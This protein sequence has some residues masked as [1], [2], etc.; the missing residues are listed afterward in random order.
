M[1][2]YLMIA[3]ALLV[4]AG[5]FSAL[6]WLGSHFA[7]YALT[8]DR[9]SIDKPAPQLLDLGSSAVLDLHGS[10]F[11]KQTS[12][13][14]FMD[15]NSNEAVIGSFPLKGVFN[16]SLLYGDFL[17]LGS[18]SD[19]LK[20][21]NVKNPQ[22]PQLLKEYLVGISIADIQRSGNRLFLSRGQL[23]I[24]IMQIRKDGF[25]VH[26][27]DILLG[28]AVRAC[29]FVDGFLFVAAGSQGLLVYDVRQLEQIELVRIIKPGTFV[30]KI[31]VSGEFLFYTS[32]KNKIEIY[33][34]TEPKMPVFAGTI[35][36]SAP[37]RDILV[38]Q[39]RLY[40]ATAKGLFLYD[41]ADPGQP[42][43]LNNWFDFGSVMKIFPGLKHIY[44]SDSLSGLRIVD[45][46]AEY[47][48]G[49]INL[50]IDPRIIVE[51]SNC[52]YVAG[53]NKGILI[54]DKN[55][56]LSRQAVKTINIPGYSL[57]IFIKKHW[58]YI[59][60]SE[61]GVLLKDLAV[62]DNTI[63][64]LTSRG[65]ESFIAD[66]NLLF[67]AQA[68][69]GIEIFDI[70]DP[71]N[72]KSIAVWPERKALRLTVADGYLV[73]SKGH[74][75]IELI[76]ISDIKQ[77]I[78]KDVLPYIHV[79]NIVS[80]GHFI[81]VA[82]KN[83]GL[84]IYEI[85]DNSKL[86][87]LSSLSTPFPMNRFD[88]TMAVHVQEGIA[89]VANGRSGLLIIDVKNPEKPKILSSIDL[90]GFC[91]GLRVSDAK[92]FIISHCSGISVVNIEDPEKPVL[93]CSISMLGLSRGLQVVDDLIYVL[94][95]RRGVTVIPVPMEAT[96]I[97]LISR[98][99]MQVKL[100][101]VKFPGCYSI[102]VGNQHE[103]VIRD[104]FV[105]YQ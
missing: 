5:G 103:S 39:N 98:Q 13:S 105:V 76:D 59:A 46:E 58:M 65:S 96:E 33:Q 31:K 40:V 91:N 53:F 73:L 24:S 18:V 54:V 29:R 9:L 8:T 32:K 70:S 22:H 62:N 75:G 57:D 63:V 69:M 11:N 14:L 10:G 17:Y 36:L 97:D 95:K 1:K 16:G 37:P 50:G 2:R 94:H 82:S 101:P 4:F 66:R 12:V 68:K 60:D 80:D 51:I 38:Q 87:M 81:Y 100:P 61:G 3:V 77:P 78:V 52:L 26:V 99:H 90:P 44:I 83:S 64:K 23:G 67:V 72:S 27:K 84:L 21:L 89:Y 43:L 6:A 92:I 55:A 45:P 71:E 34:I 42:E 20:V 56:I 49:Y 19:G 7:S 93:F 104:G 102:Q 47:S 85:T 86:R 28:Q 88:F 15:V 48:S 74:F 41:L 35:E 25:L 79:L 30:K